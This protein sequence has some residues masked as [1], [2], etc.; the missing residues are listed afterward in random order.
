MLGAGRIQE[1]CETSDACKMMQTA[2]DD[3]NEIIIKIDEV[4]RRTKDLPGQRLVVIPLCD[5][6]YDNQ[7]ECTDH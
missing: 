7:V 5:D 4:F 6:Y 2:V 1:A 3:Q